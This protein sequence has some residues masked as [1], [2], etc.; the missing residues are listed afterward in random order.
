MKTNLRWLGKMAFAAKGESKQWVPMDANDAVGGEDS[1]SRPMELIIMGLAGCTSMDVVSILKK[2]RVPLED[3]E[4]EIDAERADEHPKVFTKIKVK[5]VFYGE[6]IKEK[7]VERAIEL[8]ENVYCSVS[9]MLRKSAEITTSFEI[10]EPK[11]R[12]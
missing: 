4:M 9:A 3:F 10:R 2:M 12:Y 8:S 5:Y 11:V 6:G 7:Q 1:A